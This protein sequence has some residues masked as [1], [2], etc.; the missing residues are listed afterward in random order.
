MFAC[1]RGFASCP[2]KVPLDT[3]AQCKSHRIYARFKA[4][5]EMARNGQECRENVWI[6]AVNSVAKEF[7]QI[8]RKGICSKECC[9]MDWLPSQ[10]V[11]TEIALNKSL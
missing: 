7:S 6:K 2:G 1:S 11:A 5:S 8:V 10:Q 4:K 9:S 3:L